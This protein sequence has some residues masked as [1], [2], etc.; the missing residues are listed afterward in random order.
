MCIH[1]YIYIYRERERYMC[2]HKLFKQVP[3]GFRRLGRKP[4]A[5]RHHG[6][7]LFEHVV[8]L[9]IIMNPYDIIWHVFV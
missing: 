7:C 1:I 8:V 4:G 2:I 3:E 5:Q 9:A 6:T